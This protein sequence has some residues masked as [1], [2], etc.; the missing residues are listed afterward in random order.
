[1]CI[2]GSSKTPAVTTPTQ[3]TQQKT[4]TARDT[5]DAKARAAMNRKRATSTILTSGVDDTDKTGKA[6]LLGS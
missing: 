1:M 5:G 4:P 6:T 3:Y 2:F